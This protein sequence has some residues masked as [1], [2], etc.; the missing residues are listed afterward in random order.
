[1]GLLS[2]DQQQCANP[3]PTRLSAPCPVRSTLEG[4]R[5]A[6]SKGVL[7][8]YMGGGEVM[9]GCTHEAN[10]KTPTEAYW[11]LFPL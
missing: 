5:C 9:V 10:I 3:G 11:A 4:T 1:M 2:S 6:W 8:L 7:E